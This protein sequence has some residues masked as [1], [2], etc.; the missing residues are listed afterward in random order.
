[1]LTQGFTELRESGTLPSRG[2]CFIKTPGDVGVFHRAPFHPFTLLTG[3]SF[4]WAALLL[5]AGPWLLNVHIPVHRS[6][7][8]L[9]HTP[10][11]DASSEANGAIMK[12]TYTFGAH[13]KPKTPLHEIN[14]KP[15][16]KETGI[17]RAGDCPSALR[18]ALNHTSQWVK[19]HHT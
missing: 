19:L 5:P 13:I 4:L 17:V 1:M 11:L 18:D 12:S 9:P 10:L 15:Y 6:Q 2:C 3:S 7:L 16:R 8:L 14:P